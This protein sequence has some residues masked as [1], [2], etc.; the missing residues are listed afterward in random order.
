MTRRRRDWLAGILGAV[1]LLTLALPAD[2]SS[3]GRGRSGGGGGKSTAIRSG[4]GSVSAGAKR[5]A[6]IGRGGARSRGGVSVARGRAG[7]GRTWGRGIGRG[8]FP[9]RYGVGFGYGGAFFGNPYYHWGYWPFAWGYPYWGTGIYLHDHYQ[10]ERQGWEAGAG[11]VEID[12]RPRKADV[13]VDGVYAGRARDYDGRWDVLYLNPGIRAVELRRD[14]YQDLRLH[15]DI[16]RGRSYHIDQR[17]Q[18]GEGLDSRSTE[19]PP[20][21]RRTD[22]EPRRL[23]RTEH[24][25]P[26]LD[27]RR[28]ARVGSALRTGFLRLDV[29]PNDA[30][31]YL[32]GEFL[33][34]ADELKRLHGALPLAEGEH[35]LEVARPGY[36][37]ETLRVTIEADGSQTVSV[38]LRQD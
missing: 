20:Q 17:M 32:D 22:D 8:F 5:S 1:L 26:S 6:G 4:G 25:E 21:P 14:G 19:P 23:T 30:A 24:R 35:T 12:V 2:A 33:A 9:Y 18:R 34:N 27:I 16:R 7:Y 36:Q 37:T 29:L 31:V 38:D 11:T 10:H 15:L 3:R 28:D 13:Y